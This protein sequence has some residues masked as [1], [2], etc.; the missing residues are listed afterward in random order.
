M[1]SQE[2]DANLDLIRMFWDAIMLQQN[3]EELTMWRRMRDKSKKSQSAFLWRRGICD[4]TS[5][6]GRRYTEQSSLW[7]KSTVPPFVEHSVQTM[8]KQ[9]ELTQK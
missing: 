7:H 8:K 6:V 9:P 1:S 2:T 5:E 4:G 3:N